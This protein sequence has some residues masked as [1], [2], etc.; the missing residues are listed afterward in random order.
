[1]TFSKFPARLNPGHSYTV[2]VDRWLIRTTRWYHLVCSNYCRD[3]PDE[4]TLC[5]FYHWHM[6]PVTDA[7]YLLKCT[8]SFGCA[9]LCVCSSVSSLF[10]VA[11]ELR[12]HPTPHQLLIVVHNR[13]SQ[14]HA[15][16]QHSNQ[17]LCFHLKSN[18]F[19][20]PF[21]TAL[22]FSHIGARH[23]LCFAPSLLFCVSLCSFLSLCNFFSLFVVI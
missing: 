17:C 23:K 1:M 5:G 14:L 6:W 2:C 12:L 11:T 15:P 13:R 16:S 9:C 18:I 4:P 20:S 8:W 22:L 10:P 7:A 21:S 3:L 19:M